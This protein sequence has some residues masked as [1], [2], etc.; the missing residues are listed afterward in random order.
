M[1]APDLPAAAINALII[2]ALALALDAVI[3]DPPWLWR[4]LR[5]PVALIG[6]LIGW[7]DRRL[8]RDAAPA[9]ER[10]LIG[11]LFALGLIAGAAL[12]GW[13]LVYILRTLEAGAVGEII[14]ASVLLAGRSLY[15]HVRAVAEALARDGLAAGRQAVARIVGRDSDNLDQAG[16]VRGAIESLAEN[17]ADGVVAPAFWFALFGLPGMLAYKTLN[18]A[19]S[20]IGYKSARHRDFGWATARLDDLANYFPARLAARMI[21]IAALIMPG[22]SG[23]NAQRVIRFDAARHRSPNA[24]RPEAAMAGALGLALA[25]PRMY[26]TG[27]V[28]DDFM[29]GDGRHELIESDIG[30]ALRLY[31]GANLVLVALIG[32]LAMLVR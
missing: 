9:G 23:V 29:G 14:A 31:I 24:G 3:G 13:A 2:L 22:A 4:R 5:H 6:G 11:A 7:A 25:G 8:N 12:A 20:M 18:T 30:E 10:R 26:A 1:F 32:L 15:D 16:V 28:A 19:D 27:L 17:F 21:V